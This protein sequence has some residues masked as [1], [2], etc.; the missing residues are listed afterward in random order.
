MKRSRNLLDGVLHNLTPA[1][2]ANVA[3]RGRWKI[4]RHLKA[5][6][7]AIVDT[8]TGRTAPILVIEAPPR[9][10]KS[11][12]ISKYLPAWYLG[13][14]PDQRVMLAGYSASFA[15]TW[16]RKARQLLLD[17]GKKYFGLYVDPR[18]TASADWGIAGREGGMTT[19]GIGGSLTGRGAN[20]LIVD[21]PI[22]NAEEAL[23]E[24]INDNH[25]DWWQSTASTRIEPGGCAIL[26]ATRWSHNDLS[27]RLIRASERGEGTPVRRVRLP[28][29]AEENDYLKRKPG[30]PLWPERW[31]LSR[32]EK[33]RRQ[34]DEHWW[35]A[36]YQQDPPVSRERLWPAEYFCHDLWSDFFPQQFDAS[37]VAYDPALGKGK[38]D[39]GAVVFAGAI[40]DKIWVDAT[41]VRDSPEAGITRVL[42]MG[43]RHRAQA[44]TIEEVMFQSLLVPEFFRQID[45]R[46][47]YDLPMLPLAQRSPKSY[48]IS[49][50][51]P[52]LWMNKLRFRKCA[53]CELVVEQMRNFPAGRHDDGPDALELA[54][55]ALSHLQRMTTSQGGFSGE[56]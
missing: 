22:K 9:H 40:G 20:L 30:E 19:A 8:I 38:G 16:G 52:F 26:I 10:G 24:T 44:A 36:M 32:L 49:R 37:V 28:A 14:F 43:A 15:R 12:L 41:L 4:A 1:T 13:Q 55:R 45:A 48:R 25:W 33:L 6:D 31:P 7:Q 17:H 11:E 21:D 34:K 56:Y 51:G 39:Y 18:A 53:G 54:I 46:R 3:S 50:L 5:I 23:S 2:F 47:Q 42:D 29:I 35:Q 27:G